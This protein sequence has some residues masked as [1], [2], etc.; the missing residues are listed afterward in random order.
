LHNV[1]ENLVFNAS[2]FLVLLH[3][4]FLVIHIVKYKQQDDVLMAKAQNLIL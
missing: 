4:S 1:G 3:A 2:R